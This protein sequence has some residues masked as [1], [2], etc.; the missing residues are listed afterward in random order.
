MVDLAAIEHDV[1]CALEEWGIGP[2]GEEATASERHILT[3]AR[4]Q[5]VLAV[6]EE[7]AVL[8]SDVVGVVELHDAVGAVVYAGTT[9]AQVPRLVGHQSVSAAA[10][11]VAVGDGVVAA[12]GEAYHAAVAVATL[13]MPDGE[14][15]Y[16][17]VG[18]V[19]EVQAE[20]VAGIH[21]DAGVPLPSD[22]EVL[23]VLQCQLLAVA[24]VVAH[25]GGLLTAALGDG[26]PAAPG[27]AGE[28][29][30]LFEHAREVQVYVFADLYGAVASQ[31]VEELLL[32]GD[33]DHAVDGLSHLG[34]LLHTLIA[35]AVV[36]VDGFL[37]LQ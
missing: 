21:L 9:D 37:R 26:H 13:G 27:D 12:S 28:L 8:E 6:V 20:G 34:G 23:E 17:A 29:V 18:A 1:L 15:L 16:A 7:V 4:Y 3:V 31:G 5:L 24:A 22:G 2:V 25:D 19:H 11:E 36:V 14:V 35:H 33:G 32:G 30:L 10:V